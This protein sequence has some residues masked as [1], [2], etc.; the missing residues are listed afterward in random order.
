MR[1]VKGRI[2]VFWRGSAIRRTALLARWSP[3]RGSAKR[4]LSC[5]RALP[6]RAVFTRAVVPTRGPPPSPARAG[7]LSHARAPPNARAGGKGIAKTNGRESL[8]FVFVGSPLYLLKKR[9]DEKRCE[10]S[11]SSGEESQLP[12]PNPWRPSA[13]L[14]LSLSL[15]QKGPSALGRRHRFSRFGRARARAPSRVFGCARGACWGTRAGR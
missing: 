13:S 8:V 1:R 9:E 6:T 14:S 5:A 12:C 7:G 11:A 10:K 4:K 2:C 3:A 15:S